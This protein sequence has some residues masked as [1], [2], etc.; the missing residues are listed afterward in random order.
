ME[1]EPT[2]KGG[3][4]I[5]PVMVA[6]EGRSGE[7]KQFTLKLHLGAVDGEAGPSRKDGFIQTQ[8]HFGGLGS[9]TPL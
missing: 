5:T 6:G 7:S 3:K 9:H 1:K 4:G 8:P 2:G